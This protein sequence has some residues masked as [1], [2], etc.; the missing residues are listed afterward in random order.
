MGCDGG[1]I[2]KRDEL[3]RTKKKPEQVRTV[4]H[5]ELIHSQCLCNVFYCIYCNKLLNG[6]THGLLFPNVNITPV[7]SLQFFVTN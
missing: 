4:L 2:P 3:V 7:E 6:H 1:T 5:Q